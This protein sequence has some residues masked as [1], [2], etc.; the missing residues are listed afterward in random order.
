MILAPILQARKRPV[1]V[2]CRNDYGYLIPS[3]LA[4]SQTENAPLDGQQIAK[5]VEALKTRL[6]GRGGG[7]NRRGGGRSRAAVES[8]AKDT[9][10]EYVCIHLPFIA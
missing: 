6:R 7:P 4:P 9:A 5:N 3:R 1:G 8:N 10:S 2:F